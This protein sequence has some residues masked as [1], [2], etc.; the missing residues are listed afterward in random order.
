MAVVICEGVIEPLAA[1]LIAETGYWT[2]LWAGIYD[3]AVPT[4]RDSVLVAVGGSPWSK[5]IVQNAKTLADSL[6]APWVALHVLTHSRFTGAMNREEA[7]SALEL[8][9][10]LGAEVV[11]LRGGNSAR[12]ILEFARSR[13]ITKLVL[14]QPART[15]ILA[16]LRRPFLAET[17]LK[18]EHGFDIYLVQTRRA[19]PNREKRPSRVNADKP[20]SSAKVGKLLWTVVFM[21]GSLIVSSLLERLGAAEAN[22]IMV[23]LLGA[24]LASLRTG[25][26]AALVTVSWAVL[27]FNF[28]FTQ[29][30]FTLAVYD[31][32]YLPVFAI[33]FVVGTVSASLAARLRRQTELTRK[34]ETQT[35][36]LYLLGQSLAETKSMDEMLSESCDRLEQIYET[37]VAIF[38]PD[39]QGEL[40]QCAQSSGYSVDEEDLGAIHR[41]FS[42]RRP[43]NIG[44]AT[45]TGRTIRYVPI[46]SGEHTV[47]VASLAKRTSDMDPPE[48]MHLN[49]ALSLVGRA[50]DR[51]RLL[52]E[53]RRSSVEAETERVRSS[54]LRSVSHDLRTPLS[55]IAGAAEALRFGH[56]EDKTISAAATDIET[57]AQRLSL[58]VENILNLTRLQEDPTTL[59]R[60]RESADDIMHAVAEA[61]RKR[62]R[63]RRFTLSFAEDPQI[64]EVDPVLIQQLLLNYIDN[65]DKYS[66]PDTP[67]KL[68]AR[69]DHGELRLIVQDHG[70]GVEAGTDK[71]IFEKFFRGESTGDRARGSGLG[72][73]ICATI[74][75]AHGGT[76]FVE[77]AEGGGSRFGVTL[78]VIGTDREEMRG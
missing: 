66:P 60:T 54:L 29:P 26:L 5:E 57:E 48:S 9:E 64:I 4:T 71:R 21:A 23:H 33:M 27:Q 72:L 42:E 16:R 30:R 10:N 43:V 15:G 69:M 1:A 67:I 40:T 35:Y 68:S 39:G 14:G 28:F 34:Q 45:G 12:D 47:G 8:A 22:I 2:L 63:G 56:P 77:P 52:E 49:T 58:L 7:R 24:F 32:G 74:A 55:G 65:A 37:D 53:Q 59:R 19:S 17:I 51:E 76:A 18:Q 50:I 13:G 38:L 41:C 73:Y 25:P 11:T 44:T 62:Y 3:S 61:A 78:P 46:P 75:R 31:V 70:V 36:Q 6:D 20:A